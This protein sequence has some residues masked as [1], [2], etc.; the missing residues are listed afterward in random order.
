MHFVI[1]QHPNAVAS[2]FGASKSARELTEMIRKA[3]GNLKR[4]VPCEKEHEVAYTRSGFLL[5]NIIIMISR[6]R[7]LTS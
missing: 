5:K 7:S 1:F 2:K 6:K 3:S 4:Q